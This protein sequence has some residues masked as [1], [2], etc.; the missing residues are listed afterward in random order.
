MMNTAKAAFKVMGINGD[1][2]FCSCCG[3][4]GLSKVVWLAPLDPDGGVSG[5]A[6]PYGTTCAAYKLRITSEKA[7]RST[8][9]IEAAIDRKLEE[10]VNAAI[11]D[12]RK[13]FVVMGSYLVPADS[14]FSRPDAEI[15]AARD[16]RFPLLGYL[17]GRLTLK[18]AA[19]IL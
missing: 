4:T 12:I 1:E 7:T 9:K 14:D 18:Q 15:L 3:K 2:D 16:A 13:G 19:A 11:A 10:T 8:A 17:N 6:A 5:E